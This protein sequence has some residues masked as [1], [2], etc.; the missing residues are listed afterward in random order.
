M[1]CFR[2]RVYDILKIQRIEKPIMTKVKQEYDV[3]IV[4]AGFAGLKA[5]TALRETGKQVLLLEARDRVGGRSKAGEIC[6]QI[7]DLGGQWVGP[8]Q[9]LLLQQAKEFGVKIY[10][11]Y[12]KGAGLMSVKGKLKKFRFNIPR[13]PL[14]ALL[15]LGILEQRW[16]RAMASLPA[17]APWTATRAAEWDAE[18]LESWIL[19][20]VHTA[21]AREFARIVSRA[22]LCAE[23][24]QVSYLYFLEYLR[25]GHGVEHLL[26]TKKGA[27]Q[28]K[29][30]GG[31]WQ[32]AKRMADTIQDSIVLNAPV[33]AIE[34]NSES[35]KVMTATQTYTAKHLIMA[36]P[37]ILASK[38]HYSPALPTKR[39]SLHEQMPMGTVIKI[40]V[41]YA[42]PFWRKRGLNG[43]VASDD[44]YFNVVFDQSL[45]DKNIGVLVGFIDGAHAVTASAMDE[46]ARRE[47]VIADLVHYF[48][49]D[50]AHP[51]GYVEQDWIKEEWSKGCYVGHMPPG[52]MTAFGDSIR[53]PCGRIHWAGTETATHW[54]GY[55]DGALQSGVRAAQEVIESQ[56]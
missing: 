45:S 34:Q 25:Q 26:S 51:I 21:D 19:K 11:Q 43:S 27:Q 23:A 6:G 3:I 38:I 47:I 39:H 22:V 13:L 33:V 7:I 4:G 28:D 44:R 9:K 15:E 35:V 40:H 2:K 56:H 16:N 36:I 53:Q 10:P 41:A 49:E 42:R 52:V 18:S 30:V 32:I 31:A 8:E 1:A 20:H 29:F 48:G 14:H 54:V 50:A 24:D 17:D 5:A 55:L 46:Q 37:P 12:D